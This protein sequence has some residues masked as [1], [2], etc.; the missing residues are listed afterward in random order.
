MCVI[1]VCTK[2]RPD[3]D[4]LNKCAKHNKD[5][6]GIGW[7]SK[8]TVQFTKGI[9]L[10]K[11]IKL[12]NK[13]PLPYVIH[14]RL[15]SVGRVIPDLCHPFPISPKSPT[16]LSGEASAVLFHNGHWNNWEESVLRHA[17]ASN[18]EIPDGEWSDTR[19]AAWIVHAV[20]TN[21][22]RFI[23][24]KFAVLDPSGISLYGSDWYSENGVRFSNKHWQYES[25]TAYEGR[26]STGWHSTDA[27]YGNT[28]R[29]SFSTLP[30]KRLPLN[31]YEPEEPPPV[32]LRRGPQDHGHRHDPAPEGY[33]HV[34]LL[35]LRARGG[36]HAG[37]ADGPLGAAQRGQ[38][39][40]AVHPH[41]AV[42]VRARVV[43]QHHDRGPQALDLPV[44]RGEPPPVPVSRHHERGDFIEVDDA[45]LAP[46]PGREPKLVLETPAEP[47]WH[48]MAYA[49]DLEPGTVDWAAA[50][51]VD[52][53]LLDQLLENPAEWRA[54]PVRIPISRLQ[55]GRV[56]LA[57]ENPARM[58]RYT[59]GWI[60]NTTWKSVVQFRSPVLRPDLVIGDLVYGRGFFLHDFAYESSER[61][62]R[63]A[64]VFVLQTLERHVPEPSVVLT[65]I[66]WVIAGIGLFLGVLFVV[67]AKR[68]K[69]KAAEFEEGTNFPAWAR[70]SIQPRF[71]L[72]DAVGARILARAGG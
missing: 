46:D 42:R 52:Q 30:V 31:A 24:G 55:D 7:I 66:P 5:G 22:L 33:L 40:L 70:S 63:V 13:L 17:I 50:P 39:P 27:Y 51:V 57:G 35:G 36:G 16:I 19:A 37:Q 67:L 44:D 71:D 15:T 2:R 21:F 68:D 41:G 10:D 65:R 25:T 48:L 4:T 62:L 12:A 56:R 32:G 61:G 9:T 38:H 59:Q 69:R 34:L 58:E 72:L 14:F 23:S 6:V 8:K 1:L 43:H 26:S 54:Q 3:V 64:P 20:G 18:R 29:S 47:F 45:D 11:V 53:R 49:R 28:W 60:G